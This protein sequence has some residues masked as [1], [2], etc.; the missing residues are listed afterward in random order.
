MRHVL[1]AILSMGVVSCGNQMVHAPEIVYKPDSLY[2]NITDSIV[3]LL[4]AGNATPYHFYLITAVQPLLLEAT[5]RHGKT[6]VLLKSA[7]GFCEGPAAICCVAG[8]QNFFYPVQLIYPME[9]Q[10]VQI[11][12]DYRSPKTV[13]PDSSLLQQRILYNMDKRRILL[14]LSG[15]INGELSSFYYSDSIQLAPVTATY[16]VDTTSP[17][18]SIYVQ[19]GTNTKLVLTAKPD[20]KEHCFTVQTNP[21]NDKVQNKVADGTLVS[22]VYND[23]L[24]TGRIEAGTCRGIARVKIP[25]AENRKI[26]VKAIINDSSSPTLTLLSSK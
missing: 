22:F 7:D 9:D 20:K 1:I 5:T 10:L 13:N 24:M 17:V 12:K 23:G 14:P 4:D 25:F 26:T 6:T 15:E 2:S 8:R 11:K 19:P 16:L 18:T 21:L 3:L